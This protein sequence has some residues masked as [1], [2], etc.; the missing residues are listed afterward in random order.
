MLPV[1]ML[2]AHRNYIKTPMYPRSCVVP[3]HKGFNAT[4]GR[5][6]ELTS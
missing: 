4:P 5:K 2:A 1:A 3:M 6:V